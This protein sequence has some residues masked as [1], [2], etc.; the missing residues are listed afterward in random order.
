MITWIVDDSAVIPGTTTGE[1]T[2]FISQDLFSFW[3]ILNSGITY[4]DQQGYINDRLIS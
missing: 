1:A 3:S 4:A 2:Y